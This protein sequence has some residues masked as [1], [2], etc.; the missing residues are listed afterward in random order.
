MRS[1]LDLVLPPRCP[2]CGTEGSPLCDACRRPLERRLGEPPG[3]PIGLVRPLPAGLVA[4]E[5]CATFGGPV[6]EA[7]HAL[8]YGGDRRIAVPLGIAMA[9]R[10]R[11]AGIATD[12]VTHVPV[13]AARRRERGFDQ[14]EDLARACARALGVPAATLIERTGRTAALHRL[15]RDERAQTVQGVFRAVPCRVPAIAGRTIVVVD[16]VVTTGASLA[17][18]ATALLE[19]GAAAVAGLTVARDR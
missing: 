6:R 11:A 13:H 10:W 1:L 7:I 2:G 12:L 19:A 17:G 14:A 16:D 18:C 9:A 5:W 4:L 8:K 3:V 15:G